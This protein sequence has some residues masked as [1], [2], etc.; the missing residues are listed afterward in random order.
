MQLPAVPTKPWLT[1]DTNAL[2]IAVRCDEPLMKS[3][4]A[5]VLKRDGNMWEDDDVEIF[6]GMESPKDAYMHLAINALGFLYD[7]I[8]TGDRAA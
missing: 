5:R 1:Y 3:L 4:R 2:Y 6:L 8:G 7:A